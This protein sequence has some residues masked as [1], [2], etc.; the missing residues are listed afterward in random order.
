GDADN[1]PAAVATAGSVGR[2]Y[3]LNI[4]CSSPDSYISFMM[5]EPPM[6]SPFTYSCGTVGQF[7]KSLMPWRTSGSSSTLTVAML[8]TPQAFR[9]WMARPEKPHCGNCAVP[10]MNSTT[11]V[12]VTV[13]LIQV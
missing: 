9:I 10:F 6:N 2:H 3:F 4:A 11:G 1:D 13:S 12:L 7:E 5:S 8:S